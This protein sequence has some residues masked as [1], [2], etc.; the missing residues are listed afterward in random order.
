M[1]TGTT[2]TSGKVTRVPTWKGTNSSAM[3]HFTKLDTL[4]TGKNTCALKNKSKNEPFVIWQHNK[5]KLVTPILLK[6]LFLQSYNGSF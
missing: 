2:L 6:E 1:S 3:G 5:K 4:Y